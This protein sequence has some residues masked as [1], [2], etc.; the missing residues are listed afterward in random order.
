MNILKF[1]PEKNKEFWNDYAKK[2]KDNPFGAH[3][4]KHVVELE[5]NFIVS[6]LKSRKL[7]SLLDIGCGNGQRTILFS[8]LIA[9]KSKGIDYS[10]IMI[11]EAK[12]LL[13]KQSSEIK[14]NLSFEVGDINDLENLKYDVIISCR[15]IV[16][17]PSN[18]KQ[19]Q[20]FTNIYNKLKDGGSLIIAEESM[21]GI[22]RLS[23]V[24]KEFGLDR[25]AER[26]FNVPINESIVLSNIENLFSIKKIR[27]LGTF[28]YISRVLHP[29][30]VFPD[31]PKPNSKINELGLKSELIVQ[32]DIS[33]NQNAFEKFGAQL[34]IHF[35]KN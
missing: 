11:N 29:A 7:N 1:T 30:L 14:N 24:R 13:E 26:W 4:D 20:L 34:L 27:R 18:E 21:E 9:G 33:L 12:A 25:I 31:E 15:C 10:E 5:N 8:Q 6:E 22:E 2:S 28:Y 16:N 17:Q 19:I 23:N 35:T 32:K 3:S